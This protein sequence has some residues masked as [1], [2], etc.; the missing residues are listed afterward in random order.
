[1]GRFF[2]PTEELNGPTTPKACW[3]TICLATETPGVGDA[4]V[5]FEFEHPAPM[6]AAA[7]R[8]ASDEVTRAGARSRLQRPL[9]PIGPWWQHPSTLSTRDSHVGKLTRQTPPPDM[10]GAPS[11]SYGGSRGRTEHRT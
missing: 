3:A 6:A 8:V 2:N 9:P 11:W 7:A 10:S 5:E 4:V 1:M